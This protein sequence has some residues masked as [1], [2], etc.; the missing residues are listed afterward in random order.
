[1]DRQPRTPSARIA[2]DVLDAALVLLDTE[3][4]DFFTVRAIAARAG[5]APMAL[6]NHFD[7]KNG[8]LEAIWTEGFE[9]LA[10]CVGRQRGEPLD[11]LRAAGLAYREFAL[12]H[13][14]HYTVMFIHRFTGFEPSP[15]AAHVAARAFGAI[16]A[17][18]ERAQRQGLF[19][20][21][22]APDVA[23][24]LWSACHGYSS[25]DLLNVN[26][27]HDADDAFATLVD[28]LV[29]GLA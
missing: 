16:V 23:Q 13:R 1:M 29:R 27:A 2:P 24:M 12:S 9:L 5:V 21:R 25:L 18:V 4:P 28:A 11:D 19:E 26:F 7:G 15:E 22:R 10:E 20:A 8:V 3:G 17:H 14:A 6:Y